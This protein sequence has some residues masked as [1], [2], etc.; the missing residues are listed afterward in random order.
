VEDQMAVSN[1]CNLRLEQF[2]FGKIKY[3]CFRRNTAASTAYLQPSM[4]GKHWLVSRIYG[5]DRRIE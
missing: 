2:I 4:T 1:K 3:I 5:Y